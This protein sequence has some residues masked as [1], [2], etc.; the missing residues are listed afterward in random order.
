MADSRFYTNAGPFRLSEVASHIGSELRGN[1]E[2]VV[3]DVAPLEAATPSDVS[4]LDNPKYKSALARTRAG[5]VVISEANAHL[6]PDGISLLVSQAP[7]PDFA[8]VAAFFYPGA[9]SQPGRVDGTGISGTAHVDPTA[10]LADDVVIEHGAVVGPGAEIGAR[11]VIGA[12]TVIGS[13]VTLGRESW[14]GPNVTITHALI[15]DRVVI[16]PGTRIGQD[17]FGFA[18]GLEGHK[19]VPQ[20]GRVIVQDDVEIG[21]N[22]TID[23]GSGPDTVIGAGTKIDNLVQVAHNVTVGRNNILVAQSGVSGSSKLGDCVVVGGQVGIAGHVEIGDGAM[24][25]A[26]TGVAHSLPGGAQYGGV[27][28]RPMAQW[29]REVASLALLAKRGWRKNS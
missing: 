12:N 15:G 2:L 22:V 11:T 5:A 8:E 23:R 3:K 13:S 25:A 27:P 1:S 18:M 16:H 19:K 14:V 4:F 28:A 21:A 24:I 7:Y 17:G 9:I 26:K 29:R 6:V 10:T 20:L